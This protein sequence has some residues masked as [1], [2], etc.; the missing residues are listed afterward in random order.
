[1]AD[2]AVLIGV[3]PNPTGFSLLNGPG[4]DALR[5]GD[6]LMAADGGGVP[7]ANVHV[8]NVPSPPHKPATVEGV[9]EAFRPMVQLA[10]QS[11]L[12]EDRL[13]IFASGH[14]LGDLSNSWDTGLITSDADATYRLHVAVNRYADFMFRSQRFKQIIFLTD[15]CR[16][17]DPQWPIIPPQLPIMLNPPTGSA[18][19]RF[20]GAAANWGVQAKE[21]QFD[22]VWHG[23][24]TKAL[25]EALDHMPGDHR[26]RLKGADVATY[27][28][29]RIANWQER[30]AL[31]PIPEFAYDVVRDVDFGKARSLPFPMKLEVGPNATGRKARLLFD[32]QGHP[33]DEVVLASGAMSW[34][35]R[36]G[37]YI[38]EV[39]D[40]QIRIPLSVPA[41][42]TIHVP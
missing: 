30:A 2:H 21:S 38:L 18:P 27:V 36:P 35:M 14:G 19:R 32:G 23:Y 7:A 17:V 5:F 28:H 3:Q 4:N 40:T 41:D 12:Q 10:A 34:G 9:R 8:A 16:D 13:F 11:G 31:L 25:L 29:A 20:F 22:G 6:W 42:T 39:E 37:L 15:C 26:G 1:M 24:F 33:V